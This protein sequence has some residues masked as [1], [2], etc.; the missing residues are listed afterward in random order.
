MSEVNPFEPWRPRHGPDDQQR[1]SEEN[2]PPWRVPAPDPEEDEREPEWYRRPRAPEPA[3]T[4]QKD[5]PRGS[6]AIFVWLTIGLIVLALVVWAANGG[7]HLSRVVAASAALWVGLLL[8][9]V[10]GTQWSWYGRL[11]WAVSGVLAMFLCWLF[12]PTTEG[13]SLLEAENVLARMRGLPPGDIAAFN[14]QAADRQAISQDFWRYR[15]DLRNA[16]RNWV[17]LTVDKEIAEADNERGHDPQAALARLRQ[18]KASLSMTEHYGPFAPQLLQARRRALES[19]AAAL[20]NELKELTAKKKYKQAA[21]RARVAM[22][23]VD[24]EARELG[25]DQELS[26]R[27]RDWRRNNVVAWARAAEIELKN[28][29]REE[30]YVE[31]AAEGSRAVVELRPE[32]EQA[33]GGNGGGEPTILSGLYAC[34]KR[35]LTARVMKAN[36]ELALL[37]KEGKHVDVPVQARKYEAE[38]RDENIVLGNHVSL[39]GAFVPA[40]ELALKRRAE[41]LCK[42]LEE[43]LRSMNYSAVATRAKEAVKEMDEEGRAIAKSDWREPI[44]ALRRKALSVRL[45]QAR[46]TAREQLKKDQ[47]RAMGETGEKAYTDLADE[48]EAVGLRNEVE[49]FRADCRVFAKLAKDGNVEKK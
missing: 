34:R 2:A 35:A 24:P 30:K 41:I 32:V 49:K 3:W 11:A 44:T 15:D 39:P 21:D 25:L 12:V 45:D 33:L 7:T 43:L 13:N 27:L 17:R 4:P 6:G 10:V 31:V 36:E 19:Q 20:E 29:E 38:F 5:S 14:A 23:E 26:D 42:S 40:R 8:A 46:V 47:Y 37:N 16:E 18:V 1:P 22:A 28:L 48:A 9:I